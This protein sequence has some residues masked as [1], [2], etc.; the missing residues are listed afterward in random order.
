MIVA[1]IG[2]PHAYLYICGAGARGHIGLPQLV[3]AAQLFKFPEHRQQTARHTMIAIDV[4]YNNCNR[5]FIHAWY[6]WVRVLCC[7][8][9]VLAL[10]I[11][12]YRCI[13]VKT[14]YVAVANSHAR[15]L[16]NEH[17]Q[18]N[19]TQFFLWP[20]NTCTC[21]CNSYNNAWKWYDRDYQKSTIMHSRCYLL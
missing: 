12:D 18:C 15:S 8:Y 2:I 7:C 4:Y 10:Y 3:M 6:C 19:Y 17:K 21:G 11:I 16:C 1:D 13:E 9:S 20:C 5:H 14:T